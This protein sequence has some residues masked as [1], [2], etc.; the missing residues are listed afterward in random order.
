MSKDDFY[1]GEP[2]DENEQVG[3]SDA[4]FIRIWQ[5]S[6]N[7]G[8]VWI[9]CKLEGMTGDEVMRRLGYL[10]KNGIRLKNMAVFIDASK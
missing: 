6:D 10:R 3:V 2:I 8:Q 7:F 5:M 1:C 4:D 9:K